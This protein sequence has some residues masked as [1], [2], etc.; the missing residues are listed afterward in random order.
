MVR[1][2]GASMQTRHSNRPAF[3]IWERRKIHVIRFCH[4]GAAFDFGVI[5]SV[6]FLVLSLSPADLFLAVTLLRSQ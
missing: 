4:E 2:V 5:V 6:S 3:K 1:D